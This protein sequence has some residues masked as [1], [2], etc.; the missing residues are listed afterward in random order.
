[1][2][3]NS[4]GLGNVSKVNWKALTLGCADFSW[5]EVYYYLTAN[6]ITEV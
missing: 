1:M 3:Y 6:V 4:S 2:L 5:D